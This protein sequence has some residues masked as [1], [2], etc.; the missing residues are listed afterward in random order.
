VDDDEDDA[1]DATAGTN[2]VLSI[3]D[4]FILLLSSA[5]PLYLLKLYSNNDMID[6][7]VAMQGSLRVLRNGD[8]DAT[9]ISWRKMI[10]IGVW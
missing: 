1:V 6:S 5:S 7:P 10:R 4:I 9:D 2:K 8:A 3:V